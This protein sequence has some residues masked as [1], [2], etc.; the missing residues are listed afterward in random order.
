MLQTL[1]EQCSGSLERLQSREQLRESERRFRDLFDNSPD[2]ILVEDLDG[3]V[4]DVN[5][6]ACVLHGMT[7]DQLIGKNALTDLVPPAQ[8]EV[9]P[10]RFSKADGGQTVL[11]RGRKPDRRR[12]VHAR[13][14]ACRAH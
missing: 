8:R 13:G 10:E 2:A 6:A 7:R 9:R 14:G 12:P 5:F 3:T 11:D 1:A 4:L